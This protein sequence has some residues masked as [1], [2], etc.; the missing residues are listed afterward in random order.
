MKEGRNVRRRASFFYVWLC[1][2]QHVIKGGVWLISYQMVCRGG[3]AQIYGL[4][5]AAACNSRLVKG[6]SK[7]SK[8]RQAAAATKGN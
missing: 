3:R 5:G 2:S 1:Q 8:Q 7:P 6:A 4:A